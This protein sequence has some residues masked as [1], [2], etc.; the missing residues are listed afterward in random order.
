MRTA[1]ALAW[2]LVP[3]LLW[4]APAAPEKDDKA[5]GPIETLRK[6]LDAP[7]TLKIEKQPLSAAIEKLHEKTGLP[8]VLDA[9]AM[10][11][12]QQQ[13][14]V[15]PD[16]MAPVDVNLKDVKLR[17]ALRTILAPYN[18]SFAPVGDSILVTT[19]DMAMFRQMHQRISVDMTKVDLAT[20]LRQISRDTAANL[21][22][23]S[24]AEKEAK[25]EV[26]LQLED[27]P[28]ETAVRLLS[29]MA[30]LKPIR[31]G[32]T[33][34]VTK[35]ETANELRNDPDFAPPNPPGVAT[36][37]AIPFNAI[38]GLGGPGGPGAQFIIGNTVAVPAQPALPPALAPVPVPPAVPAA[39]SGP[40]S[41]TG[42][43]PAP[44]AEVKKAEDA[45]KDP[46]PDK[47]EDK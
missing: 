40:A 35:K 42:G 5:A 19:E 14:G 47:K 29:E 39:P 32:N 3:G 16:Q 10:Q 37:Y 1:S 30:G 15:A 41:S 23:D 38:N 33:L 46:P 25:A 18:L 7:V 6:G 44:P 28:L 9:T 43:A 45:P 27:V 24:R 17:S 22:L 36:T 34:F 4:A 20:A 12:L 13:L 31:V 2:L 21:I 26:T 11:Q 8:L